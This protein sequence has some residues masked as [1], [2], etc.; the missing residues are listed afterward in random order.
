[1]NYVEIYPIYLR[2]PQAYFLCI[3]HQAHMYPFISITRPTGESKH[4][5][6]KSRLL[7]TW[8]KTYPF[9]DLGANFKISKKSSTTYSSASYD[10]RCWLLIAK[11]IF[12]TCAEF[13]TEQTEF[14][15]PTNNSLSEFPCMCVKEP[16]IHLLGRVTHFMPKVCKQKKRPDDRL[17]TLLMQDHTQRLTILLSISERQQ[18]H[19]TKSGHGQK[20]GKRVWMDPSVHNSLNWAS[21]V[22]RPRFAHDDSVWHR[23]KVSS[24]KRRR[25]KSPPLS[26]SSWNSSSPKSR[27]STPCKMRRE[28]VV[29]TKKEKTVH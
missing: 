13:R 9:A 28:R 26:Y 11:F 1:M 6:N 5:V 4:Y 8:E 27:L 2:P 17:S 18:Q 14:L 24:G 16:L 15:F 20:S 29:L 22:R 25:R 19:R 12:G 21:L 7:E 3:S 10:E 23:C